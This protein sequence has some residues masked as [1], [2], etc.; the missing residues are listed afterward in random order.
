[1]YVYVYV[2]VYVY[3][4]MY[5]YVYVCM[6]CAFVHTYVVRVCVSRTHAAPARVFV[7]NQ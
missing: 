7:W 1:M 4:Y 5:V 3:M 2:Y 6:L